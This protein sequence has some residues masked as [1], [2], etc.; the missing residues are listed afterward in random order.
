MSKIRPLVRLTL[1]GT[2]WVLICVT[3]PTEASG[4]EK[5]T[6][7]TLVQDSGGDRISVGS[8]A[9]LTKPPL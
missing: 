3:E 7:G 2:A 1:P 8:E 6:L 5:V 4:S 9:S